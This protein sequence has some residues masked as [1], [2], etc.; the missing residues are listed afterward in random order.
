MTF[1]ADKS[2]PSDEEIQEAVIYAN[3]KD[4]VVRLYWVNTGHYLDNIIIYPGNTFEEAKSAIP[5]VVG[6]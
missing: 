6:L 1:L 2:I 5:T 3:L 4:C